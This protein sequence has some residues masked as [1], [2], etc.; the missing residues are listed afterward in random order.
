MNIYE[1]ATMQTIC[2]YCLGHNLPDE[3]LARKTCDK[4]K[5]GLVL[6]YPE[7]Q[8]L[9]DEVSYLRR[10]IAELEVKS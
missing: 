7:I 6:K 9:L 1:L 4:C 8:I 10:R 2:E 3:A 5:N